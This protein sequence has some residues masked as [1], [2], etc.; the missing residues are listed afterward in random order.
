MFG[1]KVIWEV[2]IQI[3]LCIYVCIFCGKILNFMYFFEAD[4]QEEIIWRVWWMMRKKYIIIRFKIKTIILKVNYWKY[5]VWL[6]IFERELSN[7][8]ICRQVVSYICYMFLYK[9]IIYKFLKIFDKFL[10]FLFQ[11]FLTICQNV[12]LCYLQHNLLFFL[13]ITRI[14]KPIG[15]ISW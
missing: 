14:N 11:L 12:D 10:E 13:K 9:F 1:A 7:I 3:I 2:Y 15:A 6:P 5:R 4:T 8:L